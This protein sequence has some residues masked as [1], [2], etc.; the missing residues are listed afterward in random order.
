M[1]Y[2][3]FQKQSVRAK[4]LHLSPFSESLCSYYDE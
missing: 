2:F 4:N 3:P 1:E